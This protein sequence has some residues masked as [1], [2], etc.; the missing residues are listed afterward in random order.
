MTSALKVLCWEDIDLWILRDPLRDGGRDRLAMQILLRFHKGHNKEMVPTWYPFIE[1]KLPVLCPPSHLLA[2]ALAEGVVDLPGYD[3][4]EPFFNTKIS[5]SAVRIPWKEEFWHKPVFRRTVESIEG[6]KKSDDALTADAF[7]HNSSKLGQAAGLPDP[8]QSYVYRRG[9]LEILDKH[10]K[11]SIRDQGARHRA[12][13]TV[14]QRYYANAMRNAVAQD[15]GLGRGTESPYLDILNHIGLQYDEN[16]PTGASDE[17]MRAVGPNSTIRRLERQWEELEASL[18]VQYGRPTK[19]TGAD[20]EKRVQMQYDLRVARQQHRRKV[21]EILRKDHFKKRNNDEFDRQ[22]RGLHESQSP[23]QTVVFCLRERR[24]L[25]AILGDLDE[26]LS[27]D[28]IV[29]RKVDA[30]NAWVDYAWKIEPKESDPLPLPGDIQTPPESSI[31]PRASQASLALPEPGQRILAPKPWYTSMIHEPVCPP[32]TALQPLAVVRDSPPH[33]AGGAVE[34]SPAAMP[35]EDGTATLRDSR[36]IARKAVHTCIFC[37][38]GFTRKGTMW[39]CVERH[40][41][42]RTNEAVRCPRP[43]CKA[44][45]LKLDNEMHFKSHAQKV[46]NI[47]LRPKITIRLKSSMDPSENVQSTT[48]IIL[49]PRAEKPMPSRKITLRVNKG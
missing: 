9:N 43:E 29:R 36:Q 31:Q 38:R 28:E 33:G 44:M 32:Q 19:A 21:A 48:K 22:L 17:V 45:E 18:T 2:K 23:L 16:A 40:L 5:M 15:A 41:A 24:L 27:E 14:Y 37:G 12:N 42:R 26:D 39:N 10:Y 47:E 1:E 20:K 13:S 11:P 46:H 8:F 7:D 34:L 35:A 3:R 25:A 30:I 4:A 6:P 49:K